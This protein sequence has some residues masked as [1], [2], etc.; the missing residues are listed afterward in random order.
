MIS[1]P[2]A[3][4]GTATT[5]EATGNAASRSVAA[6]VVLLAAAVAALFWPTTQSLL[7]EWRDTDNLTYTHGYLI[8]AIC[9]WLLVRAGLAP[10]A[11]CKPDWRVALALVILSLCWLVAWRSGIELL[12]QVLFP[13]LGLG[14]VCAAIGV[15]SGSRFWF[16]FAYLYFA[17]PVW[18]VGNEILQTVTVVAV[19]VMLQV[20]SIPAYVVGNIVHVPAGAFE[21]AGGCSGLHFFVVAVA[22]AAIFGEIHR[23][24]LRMRVLLLM[25]AAALAMV[26]NWVRVYTI[27]VAGHLTDMQH[28]LVRVDHYYFG[29]ALFAVM[30]VVFFWL[31]SRLPLQDRN[32]QTA[33]D[34]QPAQTDARRGLMLGLAIAVAALSVGPAI[35]AMSPLTPAV[36]APGPLLPT[37]AQWSGPLPASDAWSP[38]YPGS[39][40]RQ[41]G[42]YRSNGVA[43]VAF[44][45]EYNE[46]RQGKEL[47]GFDNSILHGLTAAASARES[48][49]LPGG[50]ANRLRIGEGRDETVVLY[51]YRIGPARIANPFIA[52]LRYGA[53]TIFSNPAS[54]IVAVRAASDASAGALLNDLDAAWAASAAD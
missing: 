36:T 37:V 30:M 10:N 26:S 27:I 42:E 22:I 28:Y 25:L 46:Q 2:G 6:L 7:V 50:P 14:A 29:W 11:P 19:R 35:G 49:D 15:R 24:S 23:D 12:H 31:A 47:V 5:R 18:S 3:H 21:I 9:C 13:V 33:P 17:I 40:R 34:P 16:A 48:V 43:A 44:V 39:D 4:F 1:R 54:R 8:A 51:Y 38:S 52:Q 20:T 41:L 32:M 45:A 53:A